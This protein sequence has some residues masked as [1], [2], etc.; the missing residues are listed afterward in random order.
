MGAVCRYLE[1]DVKKWIPVH[2]IKFTRIAHTYLRILLSF[3]DS[4][5]MRLDRFD[6]NAS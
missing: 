2:A 6:L 5:T 4:I 3:L 1:R